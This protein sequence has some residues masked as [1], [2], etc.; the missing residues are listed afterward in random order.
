MSRRMKILR[1]GVIG[2]VSLILLLVA[3]AVLTVRTH[4]FRNYV[5]QKIITATEE[6]IGGRVAIG[7]F[8]FAWPKL[9]TVVTDFVI[10]G[11]EP[12]GS[13]P[14]ARAGR[15]ELDLR[16]FTSL[17]RL[18]ELAYLGVDKLEVNVLVLP[19][20]R[21]N[22]P[23][24]KLKSTSDQTAVET[25][26]DLA[27]GHFELT[28][29]L[30]RFNSQ[31]HPLDVRG[32]NL[33]AQFWYKILERGYRG[34]I[35]LQ[36]IYVVSG[37]NTPVKFT[38]TLPVAIQ[39]DRIEIDNARI[40]TAASEIL[41]NGSMANL[42]N[43]KTAAQV[44]GHIAV[45]DL[46]NLLDLPPGFNTRR[47]PST[48]ELTAN[49]TLE[50]NAIQVTGLR[51]SAFGGEIEGSASLEN[52][53]RYKVKGNLRQLD[54]GAMARALGEKDLPYSG[55][56]SGP[57]EAEGDLKASGTKTVSANARLVIAPGR[58]GIPMSGHLN[59]NYDGATNS[60]SC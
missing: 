18:F 36:P 10:H 25:V 49:A 48:V 37:R 12:A 21:T 8:E 30:I 16:L 56:V 6:R 19:D 9:H 15:V 50:G 23:T 54:L 57:I 53:A 44:S 28:N 58:K 51:L 20:G 5:K 46:K 52:M 43:P 14:F 27:I 55:R 26:V 22:I 17:K 41:I 39:C 32:N 40:S 3:G 29:S 33:R 45:A 4:W 7:S 34:L 60:V 31:Q 13:D 42:R 11:N 47:L 59:A 38:V 24:P 2:F 1:N 35:S